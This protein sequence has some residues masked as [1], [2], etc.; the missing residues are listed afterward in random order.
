MRFHDKL[1]DTTIGSKPTEKADMKALIQAIWQKIKT[2]DLPST[3]GLSDDYRGTTA[4]IQRLLGDN[5]E[6]VPF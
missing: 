6:E 4:F 2:L 1:V 5:D 3:A